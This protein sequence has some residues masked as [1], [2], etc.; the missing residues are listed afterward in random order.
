MFKGSYWITEVSHS[1]KSNVI[2]TTFAGARIPYTSL[3]DPKDSFISSYRVLF[4]KMASKARAV[5][6]QNAT[7]TPST[8]DVIIYEG[9]S[10]STDRAGKT[11]QGEVITKSTPT[12]GVTEFGI[13][14]NGYKNQKDVQKVD[15]NGTWLRAVVVKMGGEKYPIDPD[16]TMGIADGIKWSKISGTNYKFYNTTFLSNIASSEKIRTAKTEFKNPKNGKTLMLNPS[17]QLAETLGT[18]V[19]NGPVGNGPNI[20]GYG[21]G[22]SPSL[23][24]ELGLYDG[25][26]VYF[27]LS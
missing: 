16:T 10:Y 2:T 3:P 8:E 9:S 27:K 1:I 21:M 11:V 15:N 5:L 12:V 22:M 17:Y 4:D 7:T 6:K 13:P 23:M 14:Y 19:A 18:I 26:V 20:S 24:S 25:D